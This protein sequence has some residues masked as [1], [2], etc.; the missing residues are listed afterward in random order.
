MQNTASITE[1]LLKRKVIIQTTDHLTEVRLKQKFYLDLYAKPLSNIP[2]QPNQNVRLKLILRNWTPATI[3][4]IAAPR[5]YNLM[6]PERENRRNA[7]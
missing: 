6:T 1:E 5:L 2:L 7:L 4:S 3:T